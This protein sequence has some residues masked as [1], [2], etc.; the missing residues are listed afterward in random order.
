MTNANAAF[1]GRVVIRL[2]RQNGGFRGCGRFRGLGG[3]LIAGLGRRS[4][5]N[6]AETKKGSRVAPF[7][8]FP[9]DYSPALLFL[10]RRSRFF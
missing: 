6:F 8:Q 1:D 10:E 7:D 9:D 5:L 2:T 4:E 3:E